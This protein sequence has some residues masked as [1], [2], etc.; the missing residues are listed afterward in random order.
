MFQDQR[1][2]LH[3]VVKNWMAAHEI[4]RVNFVGSRCHVEKVGILLHPVLL[5]SFRISP[6]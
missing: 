4:R 1:P 5:L 6:T 3:L 2:W